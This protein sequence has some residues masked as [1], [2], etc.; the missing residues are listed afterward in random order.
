MPPPS[1]ID[2]AKVV[3]YEPKRE[4]VGLIRFVRGFGALKLTAVDVMA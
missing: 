4:A 2:C 3:S 1:G